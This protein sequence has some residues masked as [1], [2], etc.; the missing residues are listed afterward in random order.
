MVTSM[1]GYNNCYSDD[2][3]SSTQQQQQFVNQLQ[4]FQDHHQPNHHHQEIYNME[5]IGFP[6]KNLHQNTNSVIW[7]KEFFLNNKQ[8]NFMLPQ[9][10][11]HQQQQQHHFEDP[12]SSSCTVFTCEGNERPSQGLSLSLSSSNPSS[13]GLQSFE[14]RSSQQD[15]LRFGPSSSRS[16]NIQP[17]QGYLQI[18]NS[19]YLAPAQELLNEF[20]SLGTKQNDHKLKGHKESEVQDEESDIKRQNFPVDLVELQRRKT[21]LLHMLEEV[22]S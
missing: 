8:N 10:H 15:D 14:L 12:S 20:C 22:C 18:R 5:M 11:H 21:K 7:N 1:I 16:V 4:S 3:P 17:P 6:P 19:R 9:D 2:D 13:I